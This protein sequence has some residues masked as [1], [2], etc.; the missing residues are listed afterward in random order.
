[1]VTMQT[2]HIGTERAAV[3][4]LFFSGYL[5]R[6]LREGAR[7][8]PIRLLN[9]PSALHLPVRRERA[10]TLIEIVIS[11][12]ILMLLIMLAVPSVTGV[13][14]DRRLRHSLDSFNGLVYQAQE[15]SIGEH[16]PYLLVWTTNAVELHPENTLKG[17]DPKPIASLPLARGESLQLTLPF[18]LI[19]DPPPQWI[20]W[21]SGTCEPANVKFTGRDGTWSATYSPLSARSQLTA[22]VPR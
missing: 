14:A 3:R 21:P 11:V 8:R 16:R 19:K 18:A 5:R 22:Y 9:Q 13:M 20:F 2:Y 15:R 17:D 7:L 4:L 12:F 1:M 10:F 6:L